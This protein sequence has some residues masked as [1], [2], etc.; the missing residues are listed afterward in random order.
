M[1]RR[2]KLLSLLLLVSCP[3]SYA[4]LG[5]YTYK[6]QLNGVSGQW[7]RL[8]LPDAV[9]ERLQP[10]LN[11]LRIFGITPAN[12]TLELPY[13]LQVTSGHSTSRAVDFN[14]LNT[15]HNNK[16]YYFTFEVAA[17]ETVNEIRLEFDQKNFDWL[18]KLE[19]SPD[20][21]EWFTLLD[22]YRILSISNDA[23]SFQFTKLVFP[24]AN[25]H[26]YRLLVKSKEKPELTA[27]RVEQNAVSAGRLKSYQIK[28]FGLNEN[29]PAK[30]TV[31]DIELPLPV[32]V[33]RIS[34]GIN[35][36]FDYY[37]PVTLSYLADSVQTQTGWQYSYRELTSGILDSRSKNELGFGS[38]IV[39]KLRLTIYNQDNP[40]LTFDSVGLEGYEH[41]LVARFNQAATYYLVYGNNDA[42]APDYDLERFADSVPE[43]L[44]ELQAGPEQ[45]ID[46][47]PVRVTEPLFENKL[48]LWAIICTVIAVLGWFSVKMIRKA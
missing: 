17:T 35:S 37:R 14:T 30:Q 28:R 48:W 10:E 4:Q 33:S 39:R 20:M 44:T 3:F 42:Y 11:D 16:G 7:H 27:A 34:L 19:G 26:Y 21:N 38:T 12:D 15:A 8:V 40:P 2:I 22:S 46:K 47:A 45:I 6:R 29:K 32:P 5:E 41:S 31:A 18:V 1:D 9:F 36:P 24:A 23:T 13:L 25:Y 43:Q